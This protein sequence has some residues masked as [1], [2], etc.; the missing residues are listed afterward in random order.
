[1]CC[2][3]GTQY[4]G[5]TFFAVW[6]VLRLMGKKCAVLDLSSYFNLG[7]LK[8]GGFTNLHLRKKSEPRLQ[9]V[10]QRNRS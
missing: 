10:S 7:E 6:F 3:S 2:V 9:C 4:L 8:L 1:M 5:G